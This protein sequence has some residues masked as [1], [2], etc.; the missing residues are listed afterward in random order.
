MICSLVRDPSGCWCT[1]QVHSNRKN[2]TFVALTIECRKFGEFEG[3]KFPLNYL[4]NKKAKGPYI[5]ERVTSNHIK[6]QWNKALS[7]IV[8]IAAFIYRPFYNDI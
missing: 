1:I 6:Y 5:N 8:E 2:S 4:V 7:Q 3:L